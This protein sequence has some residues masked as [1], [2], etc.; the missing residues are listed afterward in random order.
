VHPQDKFRAQRAMADYARQ[1]HEQREQHDRAN[2]LEDWRRSVVGRLAPTEHSAMLGA[3]DS[4]AAEWYLS[5]CPN[6]PNGAHGLPGMQTVV[7]TRDQ[8]L[9]LHHVS[10]PTPT[11]AIFTASVAELRSEAMATRAACRERNSASLPKGV[12][13][14][15]IGAGRSTR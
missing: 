12:P 3:D 8:S 1:Q 5:H 6:S 11:G 13:F 14:N 7:S 4:Q 9:V 15:K 10:D 2:D